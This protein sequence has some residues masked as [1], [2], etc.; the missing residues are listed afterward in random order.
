MM[1]ARIK[2]VIKML[3]G[4]GFVVGI[5]LTGQVKSV[6]KGDMEIGGDKGDIKL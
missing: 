5:V 2:V 1:L 6:R 4:F 3:P